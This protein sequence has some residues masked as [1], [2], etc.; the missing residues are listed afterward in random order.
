M[1]FTFF[2]ICI[3]HSMFIVRQSPGMTDVDQYFFLQF[4]VWW[5]HTPLYSPKMVMMT[6]I[7]K[8]TWDTIRINVTESVS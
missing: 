7:F 5:L 4:R 2:T 3:S 6:P 1:C 8:F